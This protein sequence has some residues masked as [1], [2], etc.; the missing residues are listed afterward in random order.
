MELRERVEVLNT[1]VFGNGEYSTGSHKENK[2]REL[3]H[4]PSF[5]S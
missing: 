3:H 1:R 4:T 5:S 2:G